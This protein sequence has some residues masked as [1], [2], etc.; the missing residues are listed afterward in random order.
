MILTALNETGTYA[1]AAVMIGDTTF[2]MDMGRAAGVR[3]IGVTWGYGEPPE[4]LGSAA[5]A[6]ADSPHEVVD[7]VHETY[8]LTH[9]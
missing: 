6:L 1:R 3:T 7:H 9:W 2:D 4:L 5:V 8:R